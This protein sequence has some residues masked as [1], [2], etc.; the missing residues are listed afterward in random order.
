MANPE[1]KRASTETMPTPVSS[2]VVLRC[3]PGMR[4]LSADWR[5]FC[6]THGMKSQPEILAESCLVFA[7]KVNDVRPVGPGSIPDH[8]EFFTPESSSTFDSH[9]TSSPTSGMLE[10]S[11]PI[12][13]ACPSPTQVPPRLKSI[14]KNP[15]ISQRPSG[16]HFAMRVD[17]EDKD[18]Y[19]AGS[20][21]DN[22]GDGSMEDDSEDDESAWSDEYEEYD[23]YEESDDGGGTYI[24]H[25]DRTPRLV[26]IA[27]PV[28]IIDADSDY[29]G[30]FIHF[31]NSV[32]F[33][34]KD[35]VR[36]IPGRDENHD[37]G[38]EPEMTFHEQAHLM[39]A[40]EHATFEAYSVNQKDYDPSEHSPDVVDL[41]KQLF[42][43][44]INGIRTMHTDDYKPVIH[45]R[46]LHATPSNVDI[47]P[48]TEHQ[49]NAY[50]DRVVDS[51]LGFFPYLFAKD[52]YNHIL[53]NAEAATSFDDFNNIVYESNSRQLQQVITKHLTR[54]LEDAPMAVDNEILDWVAGELI[55]P[56]GRHASFRLE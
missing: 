13:S 19:E 46:T 40:S 17:I 23:E 14:L 25:S 6:G 15:I 29:E 2:T 55:E 4:V 34:L 7:T 42:M 52:E 11:T 3:A 16:F 30:S 49:V 39:H 32:R 41:D 44:Y 56:L 38:A 50:L 20:D 1:V 54:K 27:D 45:S 12:S 33:S 10:L 8:S 21:P 37:N 5:G 36:I 47:I 51:L 24:A 26:S 31:V 18:G 43:A 35:D 53:D 28:S 48:I 22:D 9:A